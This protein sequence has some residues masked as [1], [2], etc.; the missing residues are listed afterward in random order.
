MDRQARSGRVALHR[1]PLPHLE[2]CCLMAPKPWAASCAERFWAPLGN[3]WLH[4]RQVAEC[5]SGIAVVVPAE[6]PDLLVAAAYLHDVE[7]AGSV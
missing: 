3:R 2:Y 4:V 1:S 5:A 6:D 7:L